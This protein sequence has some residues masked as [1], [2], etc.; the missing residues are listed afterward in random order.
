[1]KKYDVA[2]IGGGIGGLMTAYRL[3]S[4]DPSVSVIIVERG[5]ALA[6]RKCPATS[7]QGCLHCKMC[8]IT[9]GYAGAGAFSDGKFN[10]GTAYGGKLGEELGEDVANEYIGYVDDILYSCSD[11]VTDEFGNESRD[12]PQIYESN[13]ELKLKCLQNNLRLLDMN[14]RHLGTDRNMRIMG[15]LINYLAA[16]GVELT[17]HCEVLSVESDY[18]AVG[19]YLLKIRD[20]SFG[21]YEI[22]ADNVVVATG[23]GGSKF[24]SKLCRDYNVDVLSN[25]V[26]IGVRVEMKDAIW[27]DFSDRIYEPKI[28]YKT[29]TFEDRTRMF[30]FNKGGLVSAENNNGV[31]TANGHSFSD[32]SKRTENCNF[33]ILSSINFTAPFDKP[34]EY[35]E[36]ISRLANAIGCG[37]VL[38]Q[39]FGDLIRGRRTNEHRLSQ[40]TVFPTLKATPGDISLVLPHRILTNIIETVYALDKVAPGTANDDTLLY[41]CEAKY[42]SIK[43]CHD[44]HFRITDGIYL[45]GDGSGITRGLSQAGAMGIYVADHILSQR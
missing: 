1:M 16:H 15:N 14:V 28:L 25:T 24:V 42:Y 32:N 27:R 33:A 22:T 43:P 35:V 3:V 36:S 13:Q 44:E 9:S 30:C 7:K 17:Q 8:S 31:I 20:E 41:G 2:V 11:V 45:I 40:N 18:S 23:R 29:K 10:L 4:N 19:K 6:N 38:V 21:D 26:D 34:T 12:Y 37:N 39:R 5:N